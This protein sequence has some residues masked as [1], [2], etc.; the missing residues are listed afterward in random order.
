MAA[1]GVDLDAK[2][3]IFDDYASVAVDSLIEW[4]TWHRDDLIALARGRHVEGHYRYG[5]ANF[6]EWNDG[7][8]LANT[9][10][11]LAD[12]IVYQSRAEYRSAEGER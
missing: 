7:E 10:Q 6:L 12:A 1:S 2:L 8:L 11:E 5:D 4:L 3:R 9:A